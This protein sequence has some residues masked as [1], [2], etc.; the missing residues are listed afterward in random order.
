MSEPADGGWGDPRLLLDKLSRVTGLAAGAARALRR[1]LFINLASVVVL[2]V[3]FVALGASG[4]WW[5]PCVL[6]LVAA[7]VPA[8]LVWRGVGIC[9]QIGQI[10]ETLVDVGELPGRALEGLRE[11]A[12]VVSQRGLRAALW[13][14]RTLLRDI[15]GIVPLVDFVKSFNVLSLTVTAGAV[16]AVPVVVVI[17]L[18]V[19]GFALF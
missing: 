4:W 9:D 17:A 13:E 2:L 14:S 7:L 15:A 19:A 10:P 11:V 16:L 8:V 1:V 3:G 12:P 18:A 5:L 6:V